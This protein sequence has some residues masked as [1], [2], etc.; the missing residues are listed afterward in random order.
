MSMSMQIV[1]S[2]SL[3]VLAYVAS[4]K[5]HARYPSSITAPA[6]TASVGIALILAATG[7]GYAAYRRGAEPLVE[8]LT[9]ATAA[10]AIPL[11][12]H[13]RVIAARALPALAGLVL[14]TLATLTA[15][16]VLAVGCELSPTLI[17]SIGIKSVTTPIAVELAPLVGGDP[18]LTVTLVVATGLLGAMFGPWLLNRIGVQD[19][20]ARGLAFGAVSQGFGT[21]R[22]AAEG[23]IQGAVAG[24][25]MGVAA[26]AMAMVAPVLIPRLVQ[27]LM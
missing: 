12:K 7:I 10:L 16:I 15:A 6:I 26:I 21:A 14:G 9:P 19:P 17:R 25:A 4:L 13:R 18:A 2:A 23:E 3:T 27:L 24:V 11:Y 22:A 1:V 5:L 8:L 20:V